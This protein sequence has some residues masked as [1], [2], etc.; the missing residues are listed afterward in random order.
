MP[1]GTPGVGLDDVRRNNGQFHQLLR[2]RPQRVR[3][4]K[5]LPHPDIAIQNGGGYVSQLLPLG[6]ELGVAIPSQVVLNVLQS[7][8]LS[9]PGFPGGCEALR[10]RHVRLRCGQRVVADHDPLDLPVNSTYCT[11]WRTW[12]RVAPALTAARAWSWLRQAL[13]FTVWITRSSSSFCHLERAPGASPSPNRYRTSLSIACWTSWRM[14][15]APAAS[16]II[17]FLPPCHALAPMHIAC[18]LARLC[19]RRAQPF[20]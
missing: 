17:G 20:P 8:L 2:H 7:L 15:P 10:V 3:L 5:I 19:R 6:R 9:G 13:A 1:Y 16:D 12:A 4:D 11:T 14:T 18:R